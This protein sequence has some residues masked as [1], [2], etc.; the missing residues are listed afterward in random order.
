MGI[1]MRSH[2]GVAA[3]MFQALAEKNINI[4]MIS[5]SEIK[6]SVVVD[7]KDAELAVKAVHDKFRLS[8]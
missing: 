5:T 1:G 4:Q 6:L 3:E 7:E 8:E 2:Y